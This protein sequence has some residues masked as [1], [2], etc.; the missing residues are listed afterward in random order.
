MLVVGAVAIVA[1]RSPSEVRGD[2]KE[3]KAREVLSLW[4]GA[5]DRHDVAALESMYADRVR[6][7]HANFTPKQC[8]DLL[9]TFYRD[10]PSFVQE[11]DPKTVTVQT[12]DG[13]SSLRVSFDKTYPTKD[14]TATVR[15][16]LVL[17][18]DLKI[19]EESDA[20]TDLVLDP[21]GAKVPR[22]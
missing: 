12:L 11:I 5:E 16:Y 2:D 4:N 7:Y 19:E 13:S 17:N 15:G 22:R 1:T 14:G 20:R 9:R 6:F 10:H 8:A 3:D 21:A 18:G